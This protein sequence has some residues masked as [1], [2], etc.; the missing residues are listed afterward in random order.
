[1]AFDHFLLCLI[2]WSKCLMQNAKHTLKNPVQS[3]ATMTIC[4]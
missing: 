1:M 3:G 2:F 4:L